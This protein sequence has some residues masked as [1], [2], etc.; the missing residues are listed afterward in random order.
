MF[1]TT[2]EVHSVI[3]WKDKY[4]EL[5]RTFECVPL[6]YF[7]KKKMA[8]AKVAIAMQ[9]LEIVNRW[10]AEEQANGGNDAET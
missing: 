1:T 7:V 5:H 9:S 2:Y 10:V 8:K 6:P 4:L 3:Q